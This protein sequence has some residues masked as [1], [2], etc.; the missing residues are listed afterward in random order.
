VISRP[1]ASVSLQGSLQRFE[2][3]ALAEHLEL[4]R[5]LWS[6]G[7]QWDLT[8]ETEHFRSMANVSSRWH[9]I[10]QEA[11]GRDVAPTWPGLAPL[12][13][14]EEL[15]QAIVVGALVQARV[16]LDIMKVRARSGVPAWVTSLSRYLGIDAEDVSCDLGSAHA[17]LNQFACPLKFGIQGMDALRAHFAEQP[18]IREPNRGP[19]SPSIQDEELLVPGI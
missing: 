3:G 17:F 7:R 6:E 19:T 9:E 18:L 13:V 15:R 5:L 2:L 1:G 12:P 4:A 10:I 16:L 11:A 14:E 8:L